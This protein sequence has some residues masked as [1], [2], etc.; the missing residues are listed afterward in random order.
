ATRRPAVEQLSPSSPQALEHAAEALSRQQDKRDTERGTLLVGREAEL[1]QL[2]RLFEKALRGE[3]QVVFVT[4]EPGVG[5]TTPGDTFLAQIRGRTDVRIPSG[6]CVEQYGPG[7]AYMPLLEATRRLCRAPGGERRI[8][9]LRRYAPSWLAQLPGLFDPGDRALLQQRV[10]G[11]SRERMLREMAEAAE[12]FT[13]QRG[14][15]VVL[16]DL[17][18]SDVATLD[19]L[20]D[21][22]R[23]REPAQLMILGTYRPTDVS[24]NNHPLRA[25]VQEL[26]AHNRCEE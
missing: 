8:E 19:W 24:A 22:A 6:Q 15:V 26:T 25:V 21:M 1:S 18:W 9:A 11:T 2:Q 12:L 5:K 10:Q 16:E 17:H 4:G 7:E 23:R 3:R 13:T 20:T 14:L